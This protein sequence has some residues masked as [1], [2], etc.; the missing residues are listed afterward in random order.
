MRKINF[1]VVHA[2]ATP[3][4]T[5]IES[6]QNYWKNVLK[7]KNPGYHYIIESNGNVVNIHNISLIAN[8][9][10]NFNSNAIHISYIGGIDGVRKPVDNRTAA[11]KKSLLKLLKEL[12]QKFPNAMIQG[13]RDFPNVKKACPCFNAKNEY[14]DL[15]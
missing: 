10:A 13:H 4:N 14:K 6:I 1:L 3:Q 7:W 15:K 5:K 8:G 12:K 11:Q 9:V 2:T